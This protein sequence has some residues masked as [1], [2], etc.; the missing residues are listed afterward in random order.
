[1]QIDTVS[2]VRIDLTYVTE[3]F[4]AMGFP[5]DSRRPQFDVGI[6]KIVELE[7]GASLSRD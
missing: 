7:T 3:R 5:R 1:M 2:W 6:R 4:I